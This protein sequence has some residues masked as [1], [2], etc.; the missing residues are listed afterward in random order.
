[1]QQINSD[2]FTKEIDAIKV[3]TNITKYCSKCYC[4]LKEE[5][6]VYFN[7]ANYEYICNRCACCLSEELETKRECVLEC[8]SEVSLF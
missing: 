6:G 1:M 7:S 8:E 3:L 5:D 2:F 4:E